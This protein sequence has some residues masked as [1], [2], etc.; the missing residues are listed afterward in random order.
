MRLTLQLTILLLPFL[1]LVASCGGGGDQEEPVL[2]EDAE[3]VALQVGDMPV[4]FVEVEGS[5]FHR[6]NADSCAGAQGDERE[7]CLER[8]EEW[9]RLDGYE[10]EYA[11]TDP[12]AFLSGTYRVFS[13]VSLYEDQE[14][15]A[16]AFRV[17]EGRLKE[18]LRQLDDAALV[19]IPTI[20]EESV[21]FVTMDT[22]TIG[23]RDM[24]VSLYV[25]DFLRGNVLA[26]VGAT[27]PTALASV[28]DAIDFARRLD[29]RILRVASQVSPTVSPTPTARP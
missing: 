4:D 12:W 23:T 21:A 2:I 20:G 15:A 16:E 17:G 19:E 13:V 3:A 6:T 26:R 18:E 25:V 28:D 1:F 7:E 29:E 11:A 10:I 8:L 5:A 24:S 9:G 27:S 22:Q 14:G